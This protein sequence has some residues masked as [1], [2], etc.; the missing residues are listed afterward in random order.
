MKRILATVIMSVFLIMPSLCS[1]AKQVITDGDL[2]TISAQIGSITI[3]FKDIYIKDKQLKSISTDGWNYWD[4]D[5]GYADPHINNT[6]S[7]FNTEPQKNVGFGEYN[8]PGYIGYR[9]VYITGGLIKRSGSMTIEVFP[10]MD[11]NIK[12]YILKATLNNQ[13]F[14]TGNIQIGAVVKM[15]KNNDLSDDQ[16]ALGRTLTQGVSA[17]SNGTLTVY[18]HNNSFF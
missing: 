4:P 13:S 9:D 7:Y 2:D 11:P 14:D 3:D 8:Q 15:G 12:S 5:H 6:D 10:T 1:A 18:A 17:T 16:P